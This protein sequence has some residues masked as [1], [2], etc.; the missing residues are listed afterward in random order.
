MLVARSKDEGATFA[1]EEPALDRETGAC[2]C[3]GT[4][5]LADRRGKVYPLYRAATEDVDRDM[6]L[7]TSDDRGEHFQGTSSTPGGSTHAR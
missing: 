4:R 1:P 6:T 5:A 2:G 7:L 3:C